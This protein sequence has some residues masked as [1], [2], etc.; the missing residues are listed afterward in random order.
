MYKYSKNSIICFGIVHDTLFIMSYLQT[1]NSNILYEYISLSL[2]RH[3]MFCS[4]FNAGAVKGLQQDK[5]VF[6]PCLLLGRVGPPP[7]S[8]LSTTDSNATT[9]A[10]PQHYYSAM[11]AEHNQNS[12]FGRKFFP[13]LYEVVSITTDK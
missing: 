5:P 11:H 10:N 3:N 12:P 9:I 4:D 2:V 8:L 7:L 6:Y 13:T 1:N